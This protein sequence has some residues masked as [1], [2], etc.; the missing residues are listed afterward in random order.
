MGKTDLILESCARFGG[1]VLNVAS[2]E[3]ETANPYGSFLEALGVTWEGDR[4]V[5]RERPSPAR[6]WRDICRWGKEILDVAGLPYAGLAVMGGY[7]LLEFIRSSPGNRVASGRPVVDRATLEEAMARLIRERK[8]DVLA[9]FGVEK[10]SPGVWEWVSWSLPC[11]MVPEGLLVLCEWNGDESDVPT[12]GSA[13]MVRIDPLGEPFD[14]VA[15]EE[16]HGPWRSLTSPERKAL[17][18][19]GYLARTWR[20]APVAVLASP[21]FFPSIRGCEKADPERLMGRLTELGVL[22]PSL[23]GV[24]RISRSRTAGVLGDEPLEDAEVS[25]IQAALVAS[26]ANLDQ[27]WF[28]RLARLL[29]DGSNFARLAE[30]HLSRATSALRAF[31]RDL[32]SIEHY[33]H[34]ARRWAERAPREAARTLLR[35][36]DLTDAL[37]L[38]RSGD[39]SR[40][41]ERLDLAIREES[42]RAASLLGAEF[43]LEACLADSWDEGKRAID[44]ALGRLR[45]AG[46]LRDVGIL[47]WHFACLLTAAHRATEALEY[48][49]DAL[50][51]DIAGSMDAWTLDAARVEKAQALIFK[52]SRGTKESRSLLDSVLGSD[53]FPSLP[54][55]LRF[56]AWTV[57][58]F[59]LGLLGDAEEARGALSTAEE[60]LEIHPELAPL[61]AIAYNGLARVEMDSGLIESAIRTSQKA[62]ELAKQH[63]DAY[64]EGW[65]LSNL[66]M[67]HHLAWQFGDAV[68][69][70]E[71]NLRHNLDSPAPSPNH[72]VG[73]LVLLCEV[74]RLRYVLEGEREDL[75]RA[76]GIV[77]RLERDVIPRLDGENSIRAEADRWF[78]LS[79]LA[80][81]EGDEDGA[82][83]A[84]RK[85]TQRSNKTKLNPAAWTLRNMARVLRHRGKL[86]QARQHL[87][88]AR[89]DRALY[90]EALNDVEEAALLLA[91]GKPE[92][93][94][95]LRE[96]AARKA[97]QMGNQRMRTC[98][99]GG[100][101]ER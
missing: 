56:E 43:G 72:A 33:L 39:A 37:R 47:D 101:L 83:K 22:S 12:R 78:L 97:G 59:N 50:G 79:F 19:A 65:A 3:G 68:R 20:W 88:W 21:T 5:A 41:R 61:A 58:A 38:L 57:H 66:G 75:V 55:W 54:P 32:M 91:E 100:T 44:A 8:I 35:A 93:A 10:L 71:E 62:L 40:A 80:L 74:H 95:K 34:E 81:E 25:G 53:R 64:A 82:R 51:E 16:A 1:R 29:E 92:A 42:P 70:Y 23:E 9:V 63:H 86:P 94:E 77:E 52:K 24:D 17:R 87:E 46:H 89:K 49:D 90:E 98:I 11:Q 60:M 45:R 99:L 36:I 4:L 28:Q 26:E 18:V 73:K 67:A 6:P 15:G 76:R 96:E 14:S 69:C 30:L 27:D 7:A 84:F 13:L 85:G 31:S 2:R 48:L